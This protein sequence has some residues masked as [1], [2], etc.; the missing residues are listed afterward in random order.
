MYLF[1]ALL[2]PLP[3]VPF[4]KQKITG[5]TKEKVIG[6]NAAVRNE[7]FFISCFTVSVKPTINT[8]ESSNYF[9]ILIAPFNFHSK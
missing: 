1:A 9:M 6:A 4:S 3:F 5:C 7:P 2:T 8:T